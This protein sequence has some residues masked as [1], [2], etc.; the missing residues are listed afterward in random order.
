[1]RLWILILLSFALFLPVPVMMWREGLKQAQ[2]A[3]QCSDG[4]C[5]LPALEAIVPP[6]Q[7]QPFAK[8]QQIEQ[9]NAERRQQSEACEHGGYFQS[10]T[11]L[12]NA[13]GKPSA[14]AGTG[15][16][17]SHHRTD[18]RQPAGNFGTCQNRR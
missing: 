17:L 3:A 16:K 18:K 15:N 11:G 6:M 9:H 13:P 4:L 14:G 12:D 2:A 1:M 5:R 10:I 7:Q 8:A